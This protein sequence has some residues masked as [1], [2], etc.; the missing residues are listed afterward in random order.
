VFV[1]CGTDF[2]VFGGVNFVVFWTD[3]SGFWESEYVLRVGQF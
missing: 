1:V 2:S 3:W